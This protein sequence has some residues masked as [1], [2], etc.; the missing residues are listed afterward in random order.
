MEDAQPVSVMPL[1]TC[2]YRWRV[3]KVMGN[4]DLVMDF[5]FKASLEG[6]GDLCKPDCSCME[7]CSSSPSEPLKF[8]KVAV[9]Q[10]EFPI[11]MNL[12]FFFF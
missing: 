5:G 7:G 11:L 3:R 1:S 12:S 9:L 8:P 2:W 4:E 10:S 6:L